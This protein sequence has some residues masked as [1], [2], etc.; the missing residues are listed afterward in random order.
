MGALT[1]YACFDFDTI[2]CLASKEKLNEVMM[3]KYNS[4]TTNHGEVSATYHP[5]CLVE[6]WS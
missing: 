4:M 6:V 3:G 2:P 5:H 1:W